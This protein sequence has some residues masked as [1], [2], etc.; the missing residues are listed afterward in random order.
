MVEAHISNAA[1]LFGEGMP[2]A[3]GDLAMDAVV[4][5]L[6]AIVKYLVTETLEPD[7]D[8]AVGMREAQRR[9]DPGAAGRNTLTEQ[10]RSSGRPEA[11]EMTDLLEPHLTELLGRA[12]LGAPTLAQRKQLAACRI[13]VTGAAGSIGSSL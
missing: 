2:Y 5:K 13:L 1:G 9:H 6:G 10:A 7:P 12:P 8:N 11:G 4:R 3:E